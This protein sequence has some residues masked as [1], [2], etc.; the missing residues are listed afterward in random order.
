MASASHHAAAADLGLSAIPLGERPLGQLWRLFPIMLRAYDE[1]YPQWFADEAAALASLFGSDV[2]RL[3]HIGS[4]AV[5][6]LVSKPTV[7][8]LLEVHPRASAQVVADALVAAGWSVM[9]HSDD[10]FRIDLNKG[11]TPAGFAER[12]FHLHVV[13]PGDHDELYFRDYLRGHPE[14]RDAYARLKQDL[15]LRY[16]HD[17]DAYTDAKTAFVRAATAAARQEFPERYSTDADLPT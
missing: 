8:I 17:R 5:P 1:R 11:Y 3:T 2:V 14:V 16:E 12:V 10:P 9:A 4:T 6:G 13:R 15:F 7:D